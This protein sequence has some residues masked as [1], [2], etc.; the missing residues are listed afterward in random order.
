MQQQSC[1][2][3]RLKFARRYF[4][5]LTLVHIVLLGSAGW[6]FASDE[7]PDYLQKDY[8]LSCHGLETFDFILEA[9]QLVGEWCREQNARLGDRGC[10]QESD[11]CLEE[12]IRADRPGY[13]LSISLGA[14]YT[15]ADASLSGR[16]IVFGDSR[17]ARSSDTNQTSLPTSDYSW[18]TDLSQKRLQILFGLGVEFPLGAR[19]VIRKTCVNPLASP[20]VEMLTSNTLQSNSFIQ[21]FRQNCNL[22]K[23][24]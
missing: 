4:V 24:F 2:S 21:K 15:K 9:G 20:Y 19:T 14:A 17:W 10:G 16:D 13:S 5:V 23:N 8:S 11:M 6:A 1:G 22:A 12:F 18:S 3:V 7:Q